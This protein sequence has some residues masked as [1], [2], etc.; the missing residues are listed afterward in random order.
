MAAYDFGYIGLREV[1][2]RLEQTLATLQRLERYRGHF[3]NWYDT[4]AQ[5]PLRPQYVSTVD[6]GNLAASLVVV[7]QAC[8]EL[9][10]APVIAPAAW[11]GIL[12]TVAALDDSLHA[13]RI[14]LRPRLPRRV[15]R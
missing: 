10:D 6:S 7:K 5:L 9:L 14:G 2:E 11:R 12:D 4:I 15:G 1:T 8:L 13:A 3:Y